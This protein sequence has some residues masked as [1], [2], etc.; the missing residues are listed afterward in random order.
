MYLLLK[1]MSL[2]EVMIVRILV[3]MELVWIVMFIDFDLFFRIIIG[4]FMENL[5]ERI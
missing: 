1:K 2:V 5:C 4:D 3:M